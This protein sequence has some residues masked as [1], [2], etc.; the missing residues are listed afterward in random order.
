MTIRRYVVT[1]EEG[2]H[3]GIAEVADRLR[4]A[5][6]DVVEQLDEI[7]AIIGSADESALPHIRAVR[8]VG[9]VE[10]EREIEPWSGGDDEA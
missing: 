5:G 1:L 8:G 9:A 3:D 10:E 4:A 7:G 2:V 6:F